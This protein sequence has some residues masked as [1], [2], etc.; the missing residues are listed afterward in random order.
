MSLPGHVRLL[1]IAVLVSLSGSTLAASPVT[2][3]GFGTVGLV[4]NATDKAEFIR[5]LSQPDGVAGGW[6][7]RPD[8][9]AGLQIN[10]RPRD[11][12][13][14][15]VQAVS[16]YN[17]DGSYRPHITWGFI[18]YS[19]T[20]DID[21]RAG[22]LGW[23]AYMVADS[24]NVGYSYLWVRPPMEYFGTLQL[25]HI[26]GADMVVRH[27]FGDTLASVKLYAGRA[28]ERLPLLPGTI[29][30]LKGTN[31]YG[32]HVKVQTRHWQVRL[33]FSG[34]RDHHELPAPVSD[35]LYQFRA[36]GDPAAYKLAEDFSLANKNV[37]HYS[38]GA[39]YERGSLQSQWLLDYTSTNTR[40]FPDHESALWLVGYRIGRWTPYAIAAGTWLHDFND[41]PEVAPT[42]PL[43]D[44]ASALVGLS[45]Y[46]QRNFSLGVRYDFWTKADLKLQLDRID[47]RHHPSF[48]RNVKPGWDGNTL[49]FSAV[50]DFVF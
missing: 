32:G 18:K 12:F 24:R 13:E 47:A 40:T 1:A 16:R 15:V 27:A 30:D 48:W 35:L 38:L 22:R 14:V 9:L 2:V 43:Y 3:R 20:P 31:V 26:D 11:N 29:Y 37:R 19:P 34:Y 42:S 46:E 50:I 36:S 23:D 21:L 10:Y 41:N 5:N 28:D 6:S 39:V 45:R 49:V 8:T 33:G 44:Y 17:Y 25:S 7:A 4:Y